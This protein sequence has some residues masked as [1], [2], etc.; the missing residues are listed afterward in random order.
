MGAIYLVRH[1]QA[2]FGAADYDELSTLGEE[3]ARLLGAWMRGSGLPLTQV[4][5]GSA[6][7][8]RQSAEHCLEA[9]GASG[10][11]GASGGDWKVDHGFNEFDADEV[12][13]RSRPDLADHVALKAALAADENPRRAFQHLFAAATAR[14]AGGAFDAEYTESWPQFRQRCQHALRRL[15]ESST[16]GQDIWVF[17]SGG[18]IT[19]MVQ[20]VTDI[21]D[22]RIFDINWALINTGVTKLLYRP[23]QVSLSYLNNPA[24]LDVHRRPELTTYR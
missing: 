3:Q 24:H 5:L 19:A 17:T 18:P 1:G 12:M 6:K 22:S 2:S 13:A 11:S 16:S 8:H 23:G 20:G 21:P 7:R 4:V 14:W 9:F 15:V 10:A